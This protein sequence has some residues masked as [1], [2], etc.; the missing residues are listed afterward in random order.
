MPFQGFSPSRPRWSP[1]HGLRVPAGPAPAAH[2][3]W[4]CSRAPTGR[5]AGAGR[6]GRAPPI[7]R[8][9]RPSG[10]PAPEQ[11]PPRRARAWRPPAR[12]SGPAGP[13]GAS[14]GR[15]RAAG[16]KMMKFRF[17]RQGADPQREKLKQ[18]LFA[19]HKVRRRAGGG[20]RA[21]ATSGRGR[22]RTPAGPPGSAGTARQ[23]PSIPAL[24]S[25]DSVSA[26]RTPPAS[27]CGPLRL[28]VSLGGSQLW[29]RLHLLSISFSG[30]PSAPLLS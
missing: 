6:A 16:R 8:T 4:A 11:A 19:F 18:E 13:R 7:G 15:R 27:S 9:A 25:P 10:G 20:G 24:R 14:C 30:G 23:P 22:G 26:S 28:R 21:G 29:L 12:A 3:R 1:A 5:P 17:R 2:A